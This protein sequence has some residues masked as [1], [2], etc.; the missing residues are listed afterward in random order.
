MTNH[1]PTLLVLC[2]IHGLI[3]AFCI[4]AAF[5]LF[6]SGDSMSQVLNSPVGWA[7]LMTWPALLVCFILGLIAAGLPAVSV[8]L[9]A[10]LLRKFSSHQNDAFEPVK[11]LCFVIAFVVVAF[12]FIRQFWPSSLSGQT[13]LNQSL[14]KDG[15]PMLLYLLSAVSSIAAVKVLTTGTI[16]FFSKRPR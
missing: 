10:Y 9:I 7:V 8:A 16:N 15:P 5:D 2:F 13:A 6:S 1:S 3:A 11:F 4:P 14:Y 12:M